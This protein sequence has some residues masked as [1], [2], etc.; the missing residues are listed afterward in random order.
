ME[1]SGDRCK[2]GDWGKDDGASWEGSGGR[3]ARGRKGMVRGQG[4][5]G[6]GIVLEIGPDNGVVLGDCSHPVR[7]IFIGDMFIGATKIVITNF[8]CTALRPMKL[9]VFSSAN[10]SPTDI[11]YLRWSGRK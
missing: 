3:G 8:V 10:L 1:D 6:N 5:R 9:I 2:G 4:P 11:M 7:S